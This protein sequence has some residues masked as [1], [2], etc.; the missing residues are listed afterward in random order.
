MTLLRPAST[1]SEVG[2]ADQD[3]SEHI[4]CVFLGGGQGAGCPGA[5]GAFPRRMWGQHVASVNHQ[6][7]SAVSP[8]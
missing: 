7:V 5:L 6:S 3:G 2:F 1:G 8:P 4:P